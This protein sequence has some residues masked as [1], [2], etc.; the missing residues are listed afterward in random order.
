M[1]TTNNFASR[2]TQ[3]SNYSTHK[4]SLRFLIAFTTSVRTPKLI[5]RLRITCLSFFTYTANPT[6]QTSFQLSH[7]IQSDHSIR[8]ITENR[9]FQLDRLVAPIEHLFR[10]ESLR[11]RPRTR[12]WQHWRRRQ[13]NRPLQQIELLQVV[14]N[15]RR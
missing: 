12:K 2:T 8:G 11:F 7:T 3:I 6:S 9:I 5:R 10:G 1:H 13:R 15:G 4:P 14:Q